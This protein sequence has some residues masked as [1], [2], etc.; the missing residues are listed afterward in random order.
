VS[1]TNPFSSS[2]RTCVCLHFY[3]PA[4]EWVLIKL[5]TRSTSL[6]ADYQK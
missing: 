4:N 3:F 1:Q 6:D 2:I 5:V